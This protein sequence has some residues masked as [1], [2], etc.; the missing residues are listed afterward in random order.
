MRWSGS[1]NGPKIRKGWRHWGSVA[2]GHLITLGSKHPPPIFI[3]E[4]IFHINVLPLIS[5]KP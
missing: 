5:P 2:S 4:I 3:S 1:G